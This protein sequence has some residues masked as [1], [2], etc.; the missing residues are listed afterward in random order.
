LFVLNKLLNNLID[1]AEPFKKIPLNVPLH[2]R[3]P[4]NT[5]YVQPKKQN[6]SHYAPTNSIL[7]NGNS[8]KNFD[9]YFGPPKQVKKCSK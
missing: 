5:F 3:H 4:T 9:F 2:T 7:L 8:I 1:C 6:Y